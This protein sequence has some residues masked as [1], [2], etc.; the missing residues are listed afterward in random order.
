M[1]TLDGR[2]VELGRLLGKLLFQ[3]LALFLVLLVLLEVVVEDARRVAHLAEILLYVIDLGFVGNQANALVFLVLVIHWGQL[4]EGIGHKRESESFLLSLCDCSLKLFLEV[5]LY[6]RSV[7]IGPL[8][9]NCS[10]YFSHKFVPSITTSIFRQPELL[11][12]IVENFSHIDIVLVCVIFVHHFRVLVAELR[13]LAVRDYRDQ[14]DEHVGT[15]HEHLSIN[16]SLVDVLGEV[17]GL[18]VAA[19]LPGKS[20]VL[21]LDLLDFLLLSLDLVFSLAH[22][23]SL[24]VSVGLPW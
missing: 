10:T 15:L 17:S 1:E 9:R 2:R 13:Y 3:D 19:F 21:V 18:K 16:S 8:C 14:V 4:V 22:F 20:V 6:F 24:S 7:I 23:L 12:G 5:C 11:I